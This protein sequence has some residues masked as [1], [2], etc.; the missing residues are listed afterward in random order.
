MCDMLDGKIGRK[1]L[2]LGKNSSGTGFA[3]LTVPIPEVTIDSLNI[4]L[5]I[6]FIFK[7]SAR[8]IL[9]FTGDCGVSRDFH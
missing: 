8:F 3:I 1:E 6:N 9:Y 4:Y 2:N 5:K 7:E